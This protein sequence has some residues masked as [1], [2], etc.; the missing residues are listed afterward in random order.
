MHLL[1]EIMDNHLLNMLTLDKVKC[2]EN[3]YSF[4]NKIMINDLD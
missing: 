3:K 1:T 2:I 4:I